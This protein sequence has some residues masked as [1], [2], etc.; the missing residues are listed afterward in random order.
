MASVFRS[1]RS[2]RFRALYDRLPVRAQ[3]QADT[4][5]QL[6]KQN[7]RHPSL[8]FKPVDPADPSVYS[9]RVGAH[10]RAVGLLND[11]TITWIWIG[12]HERY[13]SLDL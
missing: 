4:A 5:Y 7:P 8:Q 1:Q 13:N 10:Y 3:E 9:V 11:D 12:T 6:F 2:K